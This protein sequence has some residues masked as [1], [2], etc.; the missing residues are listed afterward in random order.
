MRDRQISCQYN[1]LSAFD[2]KVSNFDVQL[3]RWLL[4][5]GYHSRVVLTLDQL[6][7]APTRICTCNPRDRSRS[8]RGR[9]SPAHRPHW[10]PNV[11]MNGFAPNRC[12]D[13]LD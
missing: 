2:G 10:R 11:E 12:I 4:K 5:A 1:N 9:A 8:V 3:F 6:M 13:V 7:G